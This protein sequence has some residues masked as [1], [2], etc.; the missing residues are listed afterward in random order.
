LVED[1]TVPSAASQ[2]AVSAQ[3]SVNITSFDVPVTVTPPPA[4]QNTD[5]TAQAFSSG[6]D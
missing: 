6:Q 4:G 5:V 3:V 1:V 2:K